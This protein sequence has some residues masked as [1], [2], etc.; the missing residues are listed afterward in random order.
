MSGIGILRPPGYKFR[1]F[2]F[3]RLVCLSTVY[4]SAGIMPFPW[5]LA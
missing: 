3:S 4:L 2:P 5:E 1:D